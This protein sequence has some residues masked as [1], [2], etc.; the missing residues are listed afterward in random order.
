MCVICN[1]LEGFREIGREVCE[2]EREERVRGREKGM[3]E[4]R[5]HL[6]YIL[7]LKQCAQNTISLHSFKIRDNIQN[8][9]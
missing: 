3:K 1:S 6:V 7:V 2:R 5:E 9:C 8:I 4:I